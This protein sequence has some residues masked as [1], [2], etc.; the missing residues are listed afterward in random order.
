M[1]AIYSIGSQLSSSHNYFKM[2]FGRFNKYPTYTSFTSY[3][4]S[5]NLLRIAQTITNLLTREKNCYLL[6]RLPYLAIN[7]EELY[8]RGMSERPPLLVV[9]LSSG[10]NGWTTVRTY[11]NEWLFLRANNNRP[12]LSEIAM[13]LECKAFYYRVIYES[14]NLLSRW[15]E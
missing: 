5:D 14:D 15:A 8:R 2:H 1:K 3:I 7:I 11:P 13:Q 9:A 10:G 6:S 4:N 12:R